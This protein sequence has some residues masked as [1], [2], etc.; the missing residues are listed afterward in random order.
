[1]HSG[2]DSMA[3]CSPSRKLRD[4]IFINKHIVGRVNWK[5]GETINSGA[6][7]Q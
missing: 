6:V 5:C 1:M 2:G 7:T 4:H 3:A